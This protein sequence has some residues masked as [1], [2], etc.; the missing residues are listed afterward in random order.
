MQTENSREILTPPVV[1]PGIDPAR[2]GLDTPMLTCP[3]RVKSLSEL[4][5]LARQVI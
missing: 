2:R 4:A 1:A 5:T 3:H